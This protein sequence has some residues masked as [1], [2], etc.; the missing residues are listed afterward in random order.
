MQNLL[1]HFQRV[2]PLLDDSLRFFEQI[3]KDLDLG[4]ETKNTCMPFG[5][6]FISSNLNINRQPIVNICIGGSGQ[7]FPGFKRY[8]WLEKSKKFV[9]LNTDKKLIELNI[10]LRYQFKK[11]ERQS[12]VIIMI[13]QEEFAEMMI[14][15][16]DPDLKKISYFRSLYEYNEVTNDHTRSQ[17]IFIF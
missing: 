9:I 2:I 11:K 3:S 5:S 1:K 7:E 10:S 12:T 17:V 4:L 14:S 13:S 8:A 6:S 15:N 16:V